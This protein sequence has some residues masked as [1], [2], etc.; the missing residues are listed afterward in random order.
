[1]AKERA[2]RAAIRV[3]TVLQDDRR[4]GWSGVDVL[5]GG[6]RSFREPSPRGQVDRLS[7]QTHRSASSRRF[8]AGI[9]RC[10]GSIRAAA[11]IVRCDD[12]REL[13]R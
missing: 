2:R 5:A 3:R 8:Q 11:T 4:G 9:F 13:P 12:R 1:M 7:T 6:G 10:R